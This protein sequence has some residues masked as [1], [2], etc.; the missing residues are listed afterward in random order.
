MQQAWILTIEWLS[1]NKYL[2][3]GK[4]SVE[5]AIPDVFNIVV[6]RCKLRNYNPFPIKIK[7]AQ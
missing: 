5:L 2:S 7:G 6:I 3:D 1:K 4:K